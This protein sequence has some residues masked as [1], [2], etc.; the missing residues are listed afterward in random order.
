MMPLT[1]SSIA[2]WEA[3]CNN[4]TRACAAGPTWRRSISE[5]SRTLDARVISNRPRNI[6]LTTNPILF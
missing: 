6:C 5:S 3:Y 1:L 2:G 4:A